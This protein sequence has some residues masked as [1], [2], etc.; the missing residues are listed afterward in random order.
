MDVLETYEADQK[1]LAS[2]R[3]QRAEL[4]AVILVRRAASAGSFLLLTA[5]FVRQDLKKEIAQAQ[6]ELDGLD[7]FDSCVPV[8]E[9]V[10]ALSA[11]PKPGPTG[12]GRRDDEVE[13]TRSAA[14]KKAKRAFNQ[15]AKKGMAELIECGAVDGTPA[16]IARFLFTEEGLR[17]RPIGEY[18]G[19]GDAHNLEVLHA[20]SLLHDF[21]N[22]DFDKA[23]RSGRGLVAW[24][25]VGWPSSSGVVLLRPCARVFV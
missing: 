11:D 4:L 7:D 5:R 24:R 12:C 6:R 21:T 20:F 23:L 17:K 25:R 18:L 16:G 10:V 3:E 2:L 8:K 19:E 13:D 14:L 9:S 1:E 22:M 15:S